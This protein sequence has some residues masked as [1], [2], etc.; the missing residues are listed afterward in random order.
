MIVCN[1]CKTSYNVLSRLGTRS[2]C[3]YWGLGV[4]GVD[5]WYSGGGGGGEK[6]GGGWV[7]VVGGGGGGGGGGLVM[8]KKESPDFRF[9]EVG[10]SG[11]VDTQL[12]LLCAF[13]ISYPD[14]TLFSVS[15]CLGRGRS[16]YAISAFLSSVALK[17]A[18]KH[19]VCFLCCLK[20]ILK[21]IRVFTKWIS[22]YV[23][24][25]SGYADT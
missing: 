7:V 20:C 5:G 10:I 2:N 22:G 16:G 15:L 19:I 1:S 23:L 12:L 6:G 18:H 13:L 11:Y 21:R 17:P 4:R 24:A 25:L 14:L 3:A 9:P 8:Q